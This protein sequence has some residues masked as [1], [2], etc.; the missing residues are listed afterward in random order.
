MQPLYIVTKTMHNYREINVYSS[1]QKQDGNKGQNPN[2]ILVYSIEGS[3]SGVYEEPSV[4]WNT[5]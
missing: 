5:T 1:N 3:R 4:S 2:Q